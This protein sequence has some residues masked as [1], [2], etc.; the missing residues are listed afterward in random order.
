MKKNTFI[1]RI[2]GMLLIP[3]IIT[4]CDNNTDIFNTSNSTKQK[5][6][7]NL[8]EQYSIVPSTQTNLHSTEFELGIH[9]AT[10]TNPDYDI[11][12]NHGRIYVKIDNRIQFDTSLSDYEIGTTYIPNFDSKVH[13]FNVRYILPEG[14]SVL[15]KAEFIVYN[16][17][18][19]I[20]NILHSEIS[21]GYTE[22]STKFYEF[23]FD[24]NDLQPDEFYEDTGWLYIEIEFLKCQ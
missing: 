21:E 10:I 1:Q 19:G 7:K 12:Q 4:A 15:N 13:H 16:D 22:G 24:V 2:L 9:T 6:V 14:A 20:N 5:E 23:E 18:N 3:F 17:Q 11:E 8:S